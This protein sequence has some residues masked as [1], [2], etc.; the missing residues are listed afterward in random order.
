M[1][2][3][4]R[5]TGIIRSNS[6]IDDA[7][8]EAALRNMNLI[9][10][11]FDAG[12][13]AI[14]RIA[15]LEGGTEAVVYGTLW[16][17]YGTGGEIRWWLRWDGRDWNVF[18]L[19]LIA[20][21]MSN[22][23]YLAIIVEYAESPRTAELLRY[24]GEISMAIE[25]IGE[26]DYDGAAEHLKTAQETRVLPEIV[27]LTS[28]MTSTLWLNIGRTEEAIACARKIAVPDETPV[29][30]LV[31][32]QAY[33]AMEDHEKALEFA[34]LYAR[35]M[36]DCPT[37]CLQ[38]A[39]SLDALGRHVEAAD[40]WLKLLHHDPG[41]ETAQDALASTL[42]QLEAEELKAAL[43][44]F[45]DPAAVAGNLV[46]DLHYYGKEAELEA[47]VQVLDERSADSPTRHFARALLHAWREDYEPAAESFRDAWTSDP[48]RERQQE[49]M[50]SYLLMMME[51]GQATKGY[52]EVPDPVAAFEYLADDYW[53]ER[54]RLRR[55]DFEQIL[56]LHRHNH[57]HDPWANLSYGSLLL[58]DEKYVEAEQVLSAAM[59]TVRGEGVVNELFRPRHVEA[60]VR[61]GKAVE[62]YREASDQDECFLELAR[63]CDEFHRHDDLA[64]LVK[65]HRA[66]NPFDFWV[67]FYDAQLC[68]ASGDYESADR[69]FASG[70]RAAA[71]DTIAYDYRRDWIL[72]RV[73][74]GRALSAYRDVPL[75]EETFPILASTLERRNDWPS[76]KELLALHAARHPESLSLF[77][78][79][80]EYHWQTGEYDDVTK[81]LDPWPDERLGEL[82]NW[83]IR[84]LGYK[85]VRSNLRL[86]R[87]E[88]ARRAA[89]RLHQ[90]GGDTY[91]L[92]I[93]QA[94]RR[95]HSSLRRVIVEHGLAG[96]SGSLYYDDD[97]RD[98]LRSP[99]FRSFRDEYP[100]RLPLWPQLANVGL[101]LDR[102]ADLTMEHVREAARRA[103]GGDVEVSI[104]EPLATPGADKCYL[105]HSVPHKISITTL[106]RPYESDFE[107]FAGSPLES[108]YH[109]HV[110]VTIVELLPA[111]V[112]KFG[113]STGVETLL[114]SLPPAERELPSGA[115][116]RIAANLADEACLAYHVSGGM[117]RLLSND[118][119]TRAALL[120]PSPASELRKLGEVRSLAVNIY[121]DHEDRVAARDRRKRFDEF[122]DA[123]HQRRAEQEFF[124]RVSLGEGIARELQWLRL[125]SVGESMPFFTKLVGTMTTDSKLVDWL[126]KG[127]PLSVGGDD[128]V[129]WKYTDGDRVV[130]GRADRSD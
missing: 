97:C 4:V 15:L 78:W 52:T 121:E 105:V 33:E 28:L 57:P 64:Q 2:R 51:A 41:N 93:V 122:L 16:S 118:E 53:N 27:D 44:K 86:G 8:L 56:A 26:E 62:Y 113:A 43:R 124:F 101:L 19:E 47:V 75:A 80:V 12:R 17:E 88:D 37:A 48:D 87:L 70:L 114:T 31:Q 98:V 58:D 119:H 117:S 126:V 14:A 9:Q 23:E 74:A 50:R 95:D 115:L 69:F 127:E 76:L 24:F 7:T 73:D 35:Q 85:L 112:P 55:V 40:Y 100:P 83:R 106:T 94:A 107:V 79:Q 60:L 120:G 5:Q 1:V 109:N 36:G 49:Y 45:E 3:Q 77:I 59:Q 99:G 103:L 42:G 92:A 102:K 11:P 25:L 39:T 54:D 128:V 91:I 108:A 63:L 89:E 38:V 30:Y 65:I 111:G 125:K 71:D 67:D 116:C 34:R 20:G 104:V 18:D 96:Q 46:V 21:P 72:A 32:A 82:E 81:M 123:F 22:S 130:R 110:A 84:D 68:V 13:Y 129:D 29:A 61:V 6:Q 90:L 66:N 10:L